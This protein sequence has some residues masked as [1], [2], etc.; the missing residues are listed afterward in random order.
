MNQ[1]PTWCDEKIVAPAKV[2]NWAFTGPATVIGAYGVGL[3]G[4]ALNHV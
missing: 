2:L 3:F 4:A 1:V